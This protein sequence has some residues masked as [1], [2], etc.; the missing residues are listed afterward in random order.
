MTQNNLTKL[1]QTE[2]LKN[3]RIIITGCGYKPVKYK[4]YDITTNQ[5]I[6]DNIFIDNI[7][8]KLNIGSATAAV[9]A[10]KGAT[11]HLVSRTEEKLYN[12]KKELGNFVD[13]T[14][15]EYTALDLLNKEAVRKFIE[16]I[17]KDKTLNLVQSV[18]LG[19]GSYKLKDNNP[20]LR[21]EDLPLVL[22]EKESQI[23]LRATHLIMQNLLP[24]FRK[25]NET[26]V[27]I[28]TSMSAIR[29]YSLGGA[30]CAAKGALDR[31]TNAAMIDLYKDNIFLTAIRPGAVD[32]GMYDGKVVQEA[33]KNIAE[34]YNCPWKEKGIRLASPLTVGEAI[35]FVLTTNAHILSLNL[36]AKGQLPHEGS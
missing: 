32:T 28:I 22:V 14:K 18:G 2:E 16:K 8:M 25:Q 33:V 11:V 23:V 21:T 31:Y 4:F 30:H 27:A 3:K 1:I 17:P 34:E 12:L 13:G 5:A 29:G 6:E 24:Y 7:P 10:A 36:V 9:L 26:K 20:Y 35:G 15:I 19:A